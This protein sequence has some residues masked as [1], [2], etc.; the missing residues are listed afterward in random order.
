MRIIEQ[1]QDRVN[2]PKLKEEDKDREFQQLM[3]LP[4]AAFD[5]LL[6]YCQQHDHE[7]LQK[8][9]AHMEQPHLRANVLIRDSY[10]EPVQT[11]FS[12]VLYLRLPEFREIT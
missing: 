3:R 4:Q 6:L 7:L 12:F 5:P 8:L 2:N 1:V 10:K 11:S 9:Y